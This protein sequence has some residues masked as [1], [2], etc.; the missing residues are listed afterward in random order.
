MYPYEIFPGFDFYALFYLLALVSAILILRLMGDRLGW[1][2]K[3]Y[4]LALGSTVAA[5][6]VGYAA[7]IIT[8]SVY[9]WIKTGDFR[10]GTGMTFYGGLTGGILSFLAV[11][12]LAGRRVCADDGLHITTLPQLAD[13]AACCVTF[14]HATGRIGCLFAGCC[15]GERTDAW[16]GIYHVNLGYKAVPTQL[17]E[18]VFLYALFAVCAV[19]TLRGVRRVHT[20]Y[21][22]S[23]GVW[24]FVIEFFRGDDRGGSFISG[25]TPSQLSAILFVAV[26]IVLYCIERKTPIR[27]KKAT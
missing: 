12:F 14:A 16:Y 2:A 27:A 6:I 25:L 10:L 21:L 17:F 9:D 23:Y 15:H 7:S 11:Y 1:E 22:V 18:S 8:Q 26:G 5:I 24:R 19:L 20:L 4:N 13:V 3:V